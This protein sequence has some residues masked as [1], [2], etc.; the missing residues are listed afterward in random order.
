MNTEIINQKDAEEIMSKQPLSLDFDAV[1]CALNSAR[2]PSNNEYYQLPPSTIE[3]LL[4]KTGEYDGVLSRY[5]EEYGKIW[6]IEFSKGGDYDPDKFFGIYL[7]GGNRNFVVPS[8]KSKDGKPILAVCNQPHPVNVAD[9]N[10]TWN[11]TT[12]SWYLFPKVKPDCVSAEDWD[13]QA[14]VKYPLFAA[15]IN[16]QYELTP[17]VKDMRKLGVIKQYLAGN[18]DKTLKPFK[19]GG[20]YLK[21]ADL[22]DGCSYKVVGQEIKDS[23]YGGHQVLILTEIPVNHQELAASGTTDFYDYK[24]QKKIAKVRVQGSTKQLA[25]V[26]RSIQFSSDSPGLLT[27]VGRKSRKNQ[28]GKDYM[29][30]DYQLESMSP[31]MDLTELL[32]GNS[33]SFL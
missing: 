26:N 18:T 3:G 23:I 15:K 17:E 30:M 8:V 12:N 31:N 10:V 32:G 13:I 5:I 20:M 27:V 25:I 6:G 2:Y 28:D 33:D 11:F 7:D 4:S 9:F 14:G 24:G 29:L 22:V 19:S 16:V 21:V 1:V